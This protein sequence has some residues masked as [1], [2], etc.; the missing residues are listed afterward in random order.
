MCQCLNRLLS[1]RGD[2]EADKVGPIIDQILLINKEDEECCSIEDR[3]PIHLH[4]Q[5][6][7][8]DVLDSFALADV[9]ITS[10]TPI[11]T[12][13]DGYVESAAMNVYLAGCKRYVYPHS[14]FLIHNM[15]TT[16]ENKTNRNIND[17]VGYL[18]DLEMYEIDFLTKGTK[19]SESEIRNI[20][21]HNIEYLF[22][23][24]KAIE[25]GVATHDI[26]LKFN[27]NCK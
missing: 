15:K 9:M 22:G 7:G 16:L 26:V 3:N 19:I 8:G 6:G 4:I 5:S 13:C 12:Y 18:N 1:L 25:L 10:H 11:Y 27:N 21:Q 14:R 20:I 17:Y 23:S 24:A 2:I